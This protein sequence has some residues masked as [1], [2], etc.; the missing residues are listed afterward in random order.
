MSIS[1]TAIVHFRYHSLVV[2]LHYLQ[3]SLVVHLCYLRLVHVVHLR[4]L[5]HVFLVHLCYLRRALVVSLWNPQWSVILDLQ[6]R[7]TCLVL[8]QLYFPTYNA[9][10][11]VRAAMILATFFL[12]NSWVYIS[13]LDTT[14]GWIWRCCILVQGSLLLPLP[15]TLKLKEIFELF[16]NR[17][18]Q[19][20]PYDA[21]KASGSIICYYVFD[22]LGST[23]KIHSDRHPMYT[24]IT[25]ILYQ[26]YESFA[27]EN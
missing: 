9:C 22:W 2:H 15:R 5:Q 13:S 17:W 19:S 24:S 12:F 27:T 26:I 4:Y 20:I 16:Q 11:L 10:T 14:V 3:R 7:P 21:L 1:M 18:C 23:I 8:L 25:V 6:Y